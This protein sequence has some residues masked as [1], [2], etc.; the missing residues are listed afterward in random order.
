MR[1]G[2]YS[3]L[4]TSQDSVKTAESCGPHF[5]LSSENGSYTRRKAIKTKPPNTNLFEFLQKTRKII[6]GRCLLPFFC[7]HFVSLSLAKTVDSYVI[8]IFSLPDYDLK[9]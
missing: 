5:G 1:L 2:K 6:Q 7:Q 9:V 3:Q 8:H 4:K